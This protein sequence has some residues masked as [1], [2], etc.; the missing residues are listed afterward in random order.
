MP[1]V[2]N[3]KSTYFHRSL[4]QS[5]LSKENQDQTL[6]EISKPGNK[7]GNNE[8]YSPLPTH[9]SVNFKKLSPCPANRLQVG[10]CPDYIIVHNKALA[11]D[12]IDDPFTMLCNGKLF[13]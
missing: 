3:N 4:Y 13:K 12:G 11:C 2:R 8:N 5:S 7:T 6:L 9:Q 10:L 1:G